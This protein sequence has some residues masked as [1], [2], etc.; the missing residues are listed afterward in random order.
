MDKSGPRYQGVLPALRK[1]W[2]EEGFRYFGPRHAQSRC[3]WRVVSLVVSCRVVSCRVP[4][5]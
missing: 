3:V 1:I 5:P 4:Q 2:A